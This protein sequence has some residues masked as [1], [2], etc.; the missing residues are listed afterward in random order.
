MPTVFRDDYILGLKAFSQ[1]KKVDSICK[2]MNKAYKI[3]NQIPWDKN[4]NELITYLYENS[5]FEE[6]KDAI[7]GTH[8]TNFYYTQQEST[9]N[10][11]K[12][13]KIK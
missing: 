7:W 2:V 3:T 1:G 9:L 4:T 12:T 8:P 6:P 10:S 11:I 5:A 13:L